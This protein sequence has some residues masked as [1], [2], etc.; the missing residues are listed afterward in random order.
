MLVKIPINTARS[1]H[2]EVKNSFLIL[3]RPKT[4]HKAPDD[5]VLV[6]LRPKTAKNEQ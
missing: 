3:F 1:Q 2:I 5:S 6:A 4:T